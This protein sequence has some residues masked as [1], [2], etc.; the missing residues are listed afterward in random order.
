MKVKILSFYKI[1]V[2]SVNKCQTNFLTKLIFSK[3]IISN[4]V[5]IIKIVLIFSIQYTPANPNSPVPNKNSIVQITEFVPISEVVHSYGRIYIRA[6]R[7][8]TILYYTRIYI[9]NRNTNVLF[10]LL[11]YCIVTS[12]LIFSKISIL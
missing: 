12:T 3:K 8:R 7:I 1:R 5:N 10:Y 2:F 11:F 9:I 6:S 4:E